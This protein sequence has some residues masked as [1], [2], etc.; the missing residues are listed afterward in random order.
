MPKIHRE[1]LLL[2]S[3]EAMYELVNDV[4]RYPEFLPWC[5]S[6]EIHEKSD[7]LMR[8]S[9][10]VKK[11][12]VSKSFSTENSLVKNEKIAMRLLNGPFRYLQGEWQFIS[13]QT[14]GCKVILELDFEF[15]PGLINLPF[16]K[17]FEPA[18]DSMLQAFVTRAN[19]IYGK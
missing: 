17:V 14:L 19:S 10:I 13:I 4:K 1:A 8:A 5:H 15:L 3:K 7:T 12:G 16:K 11:M 6:T 18:A 9:L 2:H